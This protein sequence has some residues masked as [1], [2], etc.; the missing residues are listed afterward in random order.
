MKRFKCKECGYIHIGEEAPDVCPVCAYDKSVFVEMDQID[1]INQI[2]YTMLDELD[3]TSI[4]ILRQ[5]IENT[6]K[7]A[8]VSSAMAKSARMENNLELEKYF[9]NLSIELLEQASIYMIYSGEF[10]DFS[11]NANKLDLE[12]KLK[13]EISRL[14][15]FIDSIAN[16][17]IGEVLGVLEGNKKKL[18]ELQH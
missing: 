11:S 18:T 17:D 10:L 5:L 3:D 15:K 4:K 9:K 2:S 1:S 6:S 14:D 7:L 16:L 8:A 13:N 12:K